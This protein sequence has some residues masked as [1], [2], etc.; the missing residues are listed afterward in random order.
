MFGRTVCQQNSPI[1]T[2]HEG[3]NIQL[4]ESAISDQ[5]AIS[6]LPAYANVVQVYRCHLL[7]DHGKK[8]DRWVGCKYTCLC[9][10][11]RSIYLSICLSM[12]QYVQVSCAYTYSCIKN[13]YKQKCL[14]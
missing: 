11:Y 7:A 12:Y 1:P 8:A 10:K 14:K 6:K 13:G 9:V 5:P 2:S 3:R 4:R